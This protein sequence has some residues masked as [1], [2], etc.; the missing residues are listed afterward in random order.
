MHGDI[1]SVE[2]LLVD[3]EVE[4]TIRMTEG[5]LTIGQDG[6]VRADIVAAE[7]V[8]FGKLEGDLKVSG[9]AELRAGAVVSGNIFASRLSIEDNAVLRGQVDPTRATEPPPMAVVGARPAH[10]VQANLPVSPPR[11]PDL[12]GE[13]HGDP[14]VPSTK[15]ATG[16]SVPVV[17]ATKS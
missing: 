1:V 17:A 10:A 7:V 5:R 9:R 12:F 15:N 11:V 4:G 6:R 2:D 13:K 3:G 14:A 16:A 8:V